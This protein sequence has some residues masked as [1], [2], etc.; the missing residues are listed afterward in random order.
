MK[1]ILFACFAFIAILSICSF[2]VIEQIEKNSATVEQV[3]G[4]YVF[5][6]AK[7]LAEYETLG[8][9]K[10]GLTKTNKPGELTDALIKKARKEFPSGDALLIGDADMGRA[11][12]IKFK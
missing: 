6:R 3:N 7:P 11:E 2:M 9:V 12:V 8:S 10:P 4:L 5:Y 1:K